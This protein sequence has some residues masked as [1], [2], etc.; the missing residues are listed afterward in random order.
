MLF[1]G[2]V[3]EL[4]FTIFWTNFRIHFRINYVKFQVTIWIIFQV[5][6]RS[7]LDCILEPCL[8]LRGLFWEAWWPKSA[9]K[10]NTKCMFL[11]LHVFAILA[12]LERF[13]KPSWLVLSCF[14]AKNENPN[15]VKSGPNSDPKFDQFFDEFWSLFGV[16]FE[17][18]LDRNLTENW[19]N[20]L[21]KI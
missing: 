17:S 14:V 12:L 8:A 11:T 13:W 4:I 20:K 16:H 15:P 6:C 5:G 18:R 10:N 21:T 3:L 2:H 19:I 1:F 9:A 7:L